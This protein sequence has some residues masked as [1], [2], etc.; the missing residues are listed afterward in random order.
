[1]IMDYIGASSL[2]TFFIKTAIANHDLAFIPMFCDVCNAKEATVFLTQ[3]IEGKVQKL[4]LCESCS[5]L[6]GVHDPMGFALADLLLGLGAAQEIEKTSV[7]CPVCGFSQ[8]DFKKR[9][10][11]GCSDCYETFKEG[12]SVMLRNMHRGM[13]HTGKVP[14]KIAAAYKRASQLER[15]K[16][17]LVIA[18]QKEEYEEAGGYRDLIQKIESGEEVHEESNDT[19]PKIIQELLPLEDFS[20]VTT[21]GLTKKPLDLPPPGGE[22]NFLL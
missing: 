5:K 1:M 20:E 19:H 18:I 3:M 11:L 13:V 7:S 10:R 14:A 16:K 17:L 6:Q 4:N 2:Y 21:E 12:L 15:L 22:E 9:G 8:S